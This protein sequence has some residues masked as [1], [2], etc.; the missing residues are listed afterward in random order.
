MSIPYHYRR[1]P[2]HLLFA[3][4]LAICMVVFFSVP[5][6]ANTPGYPGNENWA[7]GFQTPGMNNVV[8]ALATD[9]VGDLY[10]GGGF[11]N[12]NGVSANYVSRWDGEA[13]HP[14][15]S[16][17]DDTVLALIADGHGNLYAGGTFTQ[18][19]SHPAS[20]IARWD[21][22]TWHPLGEGTNG[23]IVTLALGPDG[24]LYAGGS[25]WM[26]GGIEVSNV[27][28]WDGT[29]WHAVGSGFGLSLI[30]I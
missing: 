29:A 6:Q 26:A 21:G 19:G 25:F 27:A 15:G 11:T 7:A 28:M 22:T 13:W 8:Y 16:G 12:A 3:A 1:S 20:H 18:A 23:A 30:H 17:V 9:D 4:F 10:A 14:L 2:L 5:G 24:N